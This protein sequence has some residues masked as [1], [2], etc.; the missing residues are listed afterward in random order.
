[1]EKN[2]I[3]R[4]DLMNIRFLSLLL[5]AFLLM[6]SFAVADPTGGSIANVTYE[7]G[8]DSV[9][10]TVNTVAGNVTGL[11]VTGTQVTGRWAGFWG[12]ISGGIQLTDANSNQFYTWTVSDV[13]NAVVYAANSTVSAWGGAI[14]YALYSDMPNYLKTAASDNYTNTFTSNEAFTSASLNIA[15]VNYTLSKKSGGAS[16]LKTYSLRSGMNLIWAGKAI[17]DE[18]GFN[19]RI[20]DY[21][22]LVPSNSS[23]Q[24]YNFYLELP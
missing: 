4:G 24:Q 20:V 19:G 23:G 17:N 16:T 10:S 18:T 21:Q 11:N 1:M 22:I 12:N 6:V 7:R 3:F 2:K 15:S 14:T 5:G 8:S 13:T 9:T